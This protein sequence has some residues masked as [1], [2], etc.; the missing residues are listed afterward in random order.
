MEVPAGE[1]AVGLVLTQLENQRD[2]CSMYLDL[3][4]KES[5]NHL[6]PWSFHLHLIS[7]STWFIT[8]TSQRVP[9]DSSNICGEP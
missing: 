7:I 4:S 8:G 3:W 2:V 1:K 6:P 9:G 5:G